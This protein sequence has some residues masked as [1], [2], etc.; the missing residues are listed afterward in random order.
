[1]TYHM[2]AKRP[3]SETTHGRNDPVPGVSM[4]QLRLILRRIV[5]PSKGS[6]CECHQIPMTYV[7]SSHNPQVI[8]CACPYSSNIGLSAMTLYYPVQDKT[9]TRPVN[10][11]NNYT[12]IKQAENHNLSVKL[13][14]QY[15]FCIAIMSL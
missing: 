5:I 9:T 4:D 8:V 3:T 14:N 1:M 13:K 2:G 11:Q 12:K 15:E 6:Y 7:V 10:T